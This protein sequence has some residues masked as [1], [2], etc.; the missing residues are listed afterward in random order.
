[1]DVFTID[2]LFI[3]IAFIVPGFVSLKAYEIF[4]PT[5][6]IDSTKIL[7]EAITYSCINYALLF[8]PVAYF[9][10]N[11]TEFAW[12][13]NY[14]WAIFILFIMPILWAYLFKIIRLKLKPRHPIEK[15]WDFIFSQQKQYYIIVTL[16]DGNKIAGTYGEN[17]F[18]SSH[19]SEEQIFLEETWVLNKEGGLERLKE[20]TKGS[21]IL[22]SN[23]VSLEFFE[24]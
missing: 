21:I 3:F 23:M 22:F 9:Y 13:Q 2:K 15:P 17:S 6:K 14:L 19:P 16:K 4:V 11:Y 1:M 7:I 8:M 18:T 5:Q 20:S 24:R 10:N 12:Y